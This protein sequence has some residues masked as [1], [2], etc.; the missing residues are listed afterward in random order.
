ML[1]IDAGRQTRHLNLIQ[2]RQVRLNRSQEGC[3]C[4]Q[5][6]VS[7]RVQVGIVKVVEEP[8]H[9]VCEGIFESIHQPIEKRTTSNH[10]WKSKI[11]LDGEA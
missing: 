2:F 7:A 8:S 3:M 4:R 5:R 6:T 10:G 11:E 9:G 1:V